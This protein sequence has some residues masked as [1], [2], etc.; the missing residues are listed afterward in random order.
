[1]LILGSFLATFVSFVWLFPPL[2]KKLSFLL[3]H[4]SKSSDG[5]FFY[6]VSQLELEPVGAD[7][8]KSDECRSERRPDTRKIPDLTGVTR[9]CDP[10]GR[11][12]FYI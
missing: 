8:N 3:K 5:R 4:T 2:L 12:G 10:G 9:G 11:G 7:V 6:S 1:M